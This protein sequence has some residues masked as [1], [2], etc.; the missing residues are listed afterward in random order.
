MIRLRMQSGTGD[1]TGDKTK[2]AGIT[3][4]RIGPPQGTL[5]FRLK[6]GI[7]LERT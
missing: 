2:F 1:C 5:S 4:S 7:K 6:Q 3:D